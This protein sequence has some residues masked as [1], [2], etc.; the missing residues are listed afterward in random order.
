MY[1]TKIGL[2]LLAFTL[3]VVIGILLLT[4]AK[5][6]EENVFTPLTKGYDFLAQGNYEAAKNE[7]HKAVK[8]DPSNPFALN[9]LATLLEREGKLDDA[10]ATLKAAM[11]H[12]DAYKDQTERTCLAGGL[13]LAVKPKRGVGPTSSIAPIIQENIRM[14]QEK[15][16]QTKTPPP[17]E[18]P[19]PLKEN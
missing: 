11:A 2:G 8:W 13:C 1:K 5:M 19:L 6:M 16:A 3:V 18:T 14:L 12:A 10:L 15:I 9:N 7:F 17:P 4:P